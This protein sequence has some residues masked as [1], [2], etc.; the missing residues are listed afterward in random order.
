MHGA[1]SP[2]LIPQPDPAGGRGERLKSEVGR[3]RRIDT[4]PPAPVFWIVMLDVFIIE[5]PL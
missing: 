2:L 1:K 5:L 3:G 4:M